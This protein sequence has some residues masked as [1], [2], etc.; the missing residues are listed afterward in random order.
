MVL[1]LILF[2]YPLA[3]NE[4]QKRPVVASYKLSKKE[5]SFG[6]LNLGKK[7]S[8]AELFV[9]RDAGSFILPVTVIHAGP[10][11]SAAEPLLYFS[12]GPGSG[13]SVDEGTIYD[14]LGWYEGANLKRDLI[15]LDRRA[16]GFSTPKLQCS[17]YDKFSRSILNENATT[18]V[19]FELGQKV[20]LDCFA[21]LYQ[22]GFRADEFG[23]HVSSRDAFELMRALSYSRWNVFGVSYGSR[24]GLVHAGDYPDFVN[25]LIVDS[26]YPPG[27][28]LLAE[29]PDLLDSALRRYF[30]YC[31][32]NTG[33]VKALAAVSEGAGAEQVF[34]RAMA[35]LKKSPLR[36]S[37]Q[38]W[39]GGSIEVVVNDHRL[40]SALFSALYDINSIKK[41]A[42]ALAAI[43][44]GKSLVLEKLMTPFVNYALDEG[45]NSWVYFSIE[46]GENTAAQLQI[47][48]Q[49]A[50]RYPRLQPYLT[51]VFEWDSCRE[52]RKRYALAQPLMIDTDELQDKKV[53][54]LSGELDPVTPVSWAEDLHVKLKQS[55]FLRVPEVGHS[56]AANNTCVLS[57]LEEFL[58]A[59][60]EWVEI[61]QCDTR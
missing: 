26:V 53:L 12:G 36:L 54:I 15:L 1:A 22:K 17:Q 39:R 29:W 45:F 41:I 60:S 32:Q 34:W 42:P 35:A 3:D 58:G 8:C 19:E 51:G 13:V 38:D 61:Q 57:Q 18:A 40:L 43:L 21:R 23:S 28:G 31:D 56:V 27:K 4:D 14:W 24:L 49:S 47:F 20:V 46:C 25:R 37:L 59:N 9:P 48:N 5:C 30:Q 11:N 44:Q 50:L 33:C 55:K 52:L 6:S 7:I 10:E 2:F 16:T